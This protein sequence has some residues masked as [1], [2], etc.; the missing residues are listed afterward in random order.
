MEYTTNML[1][2][3]DNFNAVKKFQNMYRV[4][5]YIN[6]N[7]TNMLDANDNANSVKMFQNIYK[8]ETI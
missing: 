2:P 4:E 8:N 6:I 7:I 1:D 5:N 3:N